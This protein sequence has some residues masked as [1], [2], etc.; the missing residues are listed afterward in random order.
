MKAKSRG[1]D[2]SNPCIRLGKVCLVPESNVGLVH[3]AAEPPIYL[4]SLPLLSAKASGFKSFV[5]VPYKS[6]LPSPRVPMLCPQKFHFPNALPNPLAFPTR[7][8]VTFQY[9]WNRSEFTRL[10]WTSSAGRDSQ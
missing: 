10:D 9:F 7:H 3:F 4:S 8:P 2:I 5:L 1:E 6:N